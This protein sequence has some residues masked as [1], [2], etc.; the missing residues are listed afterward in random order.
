MQI[1]KGVYEFKCTIINTLL[2]QKLTNLGKC[3]QT[4]VW[5]HFPKF[6]SFC[7]SNVQIYKSK[8]FWLLV[9]SQIT[10]TVLIL[11]A[12]SQPGLASE[13][14]GDLICSGLSAHSSR[15][16]CSAERFHSSC[17]SVANFILAPGFC[18]GESPSME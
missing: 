8:T 1:V 16:L 10:H 3:H 7:S 17:T 15:P 12:K 14:L 2:L 13:Y 9:L 4:C 5:W 11:L 6:V 18:C